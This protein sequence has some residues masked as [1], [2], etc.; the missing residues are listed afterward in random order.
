MTVS[1]TDS[2]TIYAGNGSTASFAI[3]FMFMRDEDI[4]LVLSTAQGER[5]QTPGTD[6]ALTGAGDSTGG[7]CTMT[8]PP[9]PGEVL[10][11]R[12]NP[13]MV[14]EVDYVEN[15]A[16][17]AATHEAALDKLTMICQALA[18]RL[19]RTITF[20]ISSAV[21][22]VSL[23]DPEPGRGLAWNAA[24]DD[25]ANMDMAALDGVLLPLAVSQ[26]G[27]G[28]QTAPQALANLGF[29][30]TGV[31]LAA[32]LDPA[33]ARAAM[34]AQ[35]ADP[36]TLTA[37]TPDLLR[38]VYGDEACGNVGPNVSPDPAFEH[39]GATGGWGLAGTPTP[40]IADGVLDFTGCPVGGSIY[41]S[42]PVFGEEGK[43]YLI[44]TVVDSMT[45][46]DINALFYQHSSDEGFAENFGQLITGPG[47]YYDIVETDADSTIV[48]LKVRSAVTD[49][50]VSEFSVYPLD[51]GEEI[52]P[53]PKFMLDGT[54][55]GW[56]VT[57]AA[58]IADGVGSL[59]AE[60]DLIYYATNTYGS[61]FLCEVVVSSMTGTPILRNRRGVSGNVDHALSLGTNRILCEPLVP[62]EANWIGLMSAAG[63]TLDVTTFSISVIDG[64]PGLDL[65]TLDV[66]RNHIQWA[67]LSDSQFSDME[68]PYDGTY[69]VHVYPLGHT[70]GIAASYKSNG[71]LPDPDPDA[72]EIRITVEQYLGRKT[73]VSLQNMEV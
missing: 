24:G 17:P 67:L 25:L 34:D 45:F 31:A 48:S 70:L 13:S 60:G 50:V 3:P 4:E 39:D 7:L 11:I 72:G 33:Q 16:F 66:T 8:V 63:E 28:A 10:V 2:K 20:R 56:E 41:Y 14:Q 40:T 6:Y 65:S 19:D 47:T 44:R 49:A 43:K 23:P 53:D 15:D 52:A 9:A 73:I 51:C 1:S 62:G 5:T 55:G 18:E 37:H 26:G 57:G 12:R 46:G 36:A 38:A 27:T 54:A 59:S 42:S 69:V 64:I 71:A 22:G 68:L 61:K 35:P 32:S 30:P 29:G 21:T 58:S